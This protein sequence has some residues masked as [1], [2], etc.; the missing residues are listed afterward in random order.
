[1][2]I[3]SKLDEIYDDLSHNITFIYDRQDLL[4]AFDL[5]FHSVLS[6][7]FQGKPVHKGWVEA[8]II[9]DTR[10]GKSETAEKLVNHYRLGE[11]CSAE[12][13][14][15]AGLIGGMQQVGSR[16]HLSW[17]KIPINDRRLV[18]IDEVSGV[19]TDTIG[20]MSGI[21]ASGVAEIIKINTEKTHAR[22]RLIWLSNPRT[23]ISVNSHNSGVEI[24]QRLIGKPEDI[25]RFD[26]AL[27]MAQE[28]ISSEI[29]NAYQRKS[30]KR[31]Y[32]SDAC[33]NLLLW[34]WSRKPEQVHIDE[35][36]VLCILAKT[37]E[38]C[39][40]YSAEFPLV[41]V[42]EMK[43]KLARLATALAVRLFSTDD[44]EIVKVTKDHV[45]YIAGW[46]DKIYSRPCFSYDMWSLRSKEKATMDEEVVRMLFAGRSPQLKECL[47]ET[48][49]I[50]LT[51]IEEVIAGERKD[52]KALLTQLLAARAINKKHGF[53]VKT[54]AFIKLLREL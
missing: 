1:M 7:N 15:F 45:E 54:P 2:T 6:F 4:L 32:S 22:T 42:S 21:R 31:Q 40:D 26:F 46:L 29:I 27:I 41:T 13:T 53:Y 30:V 12:N 36:A 17:G 5:S 14:S 50:H 47:L 9:S 33:H 35:E 16:W 10:C 25:A 38:L 11:L 37:K 20:L 34:A 28:E 23:A 43:I 24:V 51:D 8:L 39:I 18:V 49:Q 19:D 52:A 48:G 3:Q 44:G